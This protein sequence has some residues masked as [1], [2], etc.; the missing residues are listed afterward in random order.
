MCDVKDKCVELAKVTWDAYIR[1]NDTILCDDKY[2]KETISKINITSIKDYNVNTF[3]L[4]NYDQFSTLNPILTTT[5][6]VL[7]YK[8]EHVSLVLHK[9][10]ISSNLVSY[11]N[12]LSKPGFT[13][14]IRPIDDKKNKTNKYYINT[15]DLECER[16]Y[17]KDLDIIEHIPISSSY[18]INN[19]KYQN[20]GLSCIEESFT[21][22]DNI[23]DSNSVIWL[24]NGG[25]YDIH[26][27]L[28][29]ITNLLDLTKEQPI[30]IVDSNQ[31]IIEMRIYLKS[32]KRFILRDSRAIVSGS[33]NMLCKSFKIPNPKID[34]VDSRSLTL[35]SFNNPRVREY[36]MVDALALQQVLQAYRDVALR[37]KFPDPLLFC[38]ITSICKHM[39]Y[40]S[41][42]P[43]C[44]S[45][46]TELN[47]QAHEYIRKSY[48]GG[49]VRAFK[50]GIYTNINSFDI[51]SCFPSA[52]TNELP[53]GTPWYS[54]TSYLISK[55]GDIPSKQCFI[56]CYVIVGK[57]PY[58]IPIH[59]Y[60]DSEG[61]EVDESLCNK[62]EQVLYCKEIELG[63]EYGYRYKMLDFIAFTDSKKILEPIFRKLYYNKLKAE[64]KHDNVKRLLYKLYSNSFYGFFGFNKYNKDIV[65]VYTSNDFN[66]TRCE[67]IVATGDGMYVD[68]G[69]IIYS[70][71]KQD[72]PIK[73]TNVAIAS[74]ITSYARIKLFK[75][76]KY[77]EDNGYNIY[78]CDTD[79]IKTNMEEVPNNDLFGEEL[80]QADKEH[81]D[82][83]VVECCIY[84]KKLMTVIYK[85]KITCKLRPHIV[86][87][88]LNFNNTYISDVDIVDLS[89]SDKISIIE[90]LKHAYINNTNIKIVQGNIRTARTNPINNLPSL[91]EK[92]YDK[93][94]L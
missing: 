12:I 31:V 15:L 60:Y 37:K 23:L 5:N 66:R 63:L 52:G 35:D 27:I 46:I 50:P 42:Y 33:L 21:N 80:G 13:S 17:N 26:I 94:I 1:A 44:N 51:K 18:I 3:I 55:K 71:Q 72:I 39:F 7:Y 82:E 84:K 90:Q 41:F 81:K 47:K 19:N 45:Y 76:G 88:G 92:T 59:L 38:T 8:R 20:I 69:S 36:A 48:H 78:Y 14:I 29:Y 6:I 87:K 16:K 10:F 34:D 70:V 64:K 79:S 73:G 28:D 68:K 30:E 2:L 24:H 61:K 62:Y 9:S 22:I 54:N 49:I 67:N 74:A 86:S 93:K 75:L 25:K 11:L 57:N 40:T 4:Y 83:T 56:R 89:D 77:I 43:Y 65:R 58:T 85:H 91:Y 32:G 53:C